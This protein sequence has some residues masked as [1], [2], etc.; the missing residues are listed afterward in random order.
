VTRLGRTGAVLAA[1][2]W[3]V[4]PRTAGSHGFEPAALDLREAGPGVFDVVWKPSGTVSVALTVRPPAHCRQVGDRGVGGPVDGPEFFRLDC[5]TKGL[6]GGPLTVEGLDGTR[7]DVL[8]RIAWR[9]GT[10]TTGVLRSGLDTMQ[11]PERGV[12]NGAPA[13]AVLAAYGRLGVEHIL[14]GTDH[15]LFVLGLLLLVP[16]WR[17][18]VATVTAF[19]VAH[20]LTLAAAVL[21][22]VTVP[23]A[24]MEVLIALS[25]VLVAGELARPLDSP[26]TLARRAPWVVSFGF[27][28]LHGLGFAGALREFGLPAD[29]LPLALLA[30]NGGVE[31]GQ[32]AF[33]ALLLPVVWWWRPWAAVR[34]WRRLL[35]AYAIGTVAAVWTWSRFVQLWPP[36]S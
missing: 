25:V 15:L 10:V 35:P 9:D 3:V 29:R 2:L 5:G 7:V 24:A 16:A 14:G 11:V 6:E 32:L 31:V 13:S 8:V 18:L 21:G 27:G 36:P 19:T 23:P 1:V 17:A 33:V 26:P 34:A 20:S 30:F 12:A 4:A 28:L 22:I